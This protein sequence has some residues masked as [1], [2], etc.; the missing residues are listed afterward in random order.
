MPQASKTFHHA[1]GF[2]CVDEVRCC[3][4]G[5]ARRARR[6]FQGLPGLLNHPAFLN[7]PAKLRYDRMLNRD[8]LPHQQHPHRSIHHACGDGSEAGRLLSHAT[9]LRSS[10][11]A[12]A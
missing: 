3:R 12:S 11:R 4:R 7:H 8:R 5:A 6:V 9:P 2:C 10:G 1:G